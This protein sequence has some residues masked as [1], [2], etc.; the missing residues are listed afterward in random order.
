[1]KNKKYNR[2]AL[3]GIIT[4]IISLVLFLNELLYGLT[5]SGNI[6]AKFAATIT[7]IL[8]L[9]A[10]SNIKGKEE[11][12]GTALSIISLCS[13]IILLLFFIVTNKMD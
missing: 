6:I 1:M 12:K 5:Q 10:L 13:S 4:L 2:L 8:S 7:I 3:V 11:T 9:I